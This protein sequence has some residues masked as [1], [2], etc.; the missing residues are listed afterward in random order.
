RR[1]AVGIAGRS[2]RYRLAAADG[3]GTGTVVV[4]GRR[5]TSDGQ[6]VVAGSGTEAVEIQVVDRA[7]GR[8]PGYA[9][10]QAAGVVVA[11]HAGQA[12]TGAGVDSHLGVKARTAGLCRDDVTRAYDG[13]PYTRAGTVAGTAA[14]GRVA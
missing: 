6:D 10:L 3:Y 2:A 11:G 5:S 1:V 12:C 14:S 9:G 4:A 13:V 8:R 7:G